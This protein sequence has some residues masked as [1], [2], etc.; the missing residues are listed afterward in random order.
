MSLIV[1]CFR[2][3]ELRSENIGRLVQVSGI[4]TRTSEVRPELMYGTF[5]CMECNRVVRDIEQQFKYTEVLLPLPLLSMF[6]RLYIELVLSILC[7]C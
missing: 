3:R 5:A 6:F 4:V 7:L 1:T 2:L